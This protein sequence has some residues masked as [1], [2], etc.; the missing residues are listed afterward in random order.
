VTQTLD[1]ST[2]Q[3]KAGDASLRF[4]ATNKRP[5]GQG[6]W[7]HVGM[8]FEAPYF[9]IGPCDALGV[10]IH[11]DGKG[12][13]L[14]LQLTTPREYMDA[15]GEHYVTVDFTGWRYFE[16]PLR[17]RDAARYR[18][19]EWPYFSLGGIYMTP[20]NRSHIGEVNLY[21]N[22]LPPNDTATVYL[23]P[24]K[25]LRTSRVQLG[26]PTVA[27]NGQK[28]TL[29]TTLHRG[30]YV[31]LTALDDCR[32]YDERGTLLARLGLQGEKPVLNAG[33][34]QIA[35]SCDR[36][37]GFSARAEITVIVSGPPLTDRTP[38]EKINWQLLRDEYDAPRVITKL[39]GQENA[40]DVVCRQGATSVPFGL[41]IDVQQVQAS[42]A[43]YN[44][45]DALTLESFDATAFFGEASVDSSAQPAYDAKGQSIAVLPGMTQT[46]ERSTDQVKIGRASA[47]YSATSTL[48]DQSG[49]SVRG[50]RYLKPLDLSKAQA[51]GFWLYGDGKGEAFKLQLRDNSGGWLDMVT[52][53]DFT[54]WRYQQ[55]DFSGP[56]KLDRANVQHLLIYYNGIPS[57]QTVT[58]YV[59]EVRAVPALAGLRNPVLTIGDQRLAFPAELS[60]G[61]RLV[62]DGGKCRLHRR[63]AAELEWIEPRGGPVVLQPGRQRVVL[64]FDSD[65]LPQFRVAASLVKHYGP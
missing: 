33:D 6:A 10:W 62:F 49:W 60:T 63:T 59:D 14:N 11:G 51:I 41:E 9:S 26:N 20:V 29:P 31:E 3:V 40:W 45:P 23:S 7:A 48:A 19:Y 1:R 28:L 36:P 44:G 38:A 39:D 27:L 64:S 65:L 55:F 30:D 12:E 5:S 22:N 42:D 57:K 16:I 25:A 47:R 37:S 43:A 32:V 52:L 17:E 8:Q 50:G 35:F 46:L 54:G 56:G 4:M 58:C 15:L 61:D 2:E 34:N 13:V 24:I 53:V 21:L 18:D